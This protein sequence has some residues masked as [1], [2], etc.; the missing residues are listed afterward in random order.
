MD[1]NAGKNAGGQSNAEVL[2]L[3]L[4]EGDRPVAPTAFA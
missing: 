4:S 3:T 1:T 2:P